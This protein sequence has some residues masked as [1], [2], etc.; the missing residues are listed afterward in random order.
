[1]AALGNLTASI[2]GVPQLV[3]HRESPELAAARGTV[4]FYHGF[5]GTKERADAYTSMLAE[6]G[7]GL[8]GVDAAAGAQPAP[9]PG[10]PSPAAVLSETAELDEFVP[11]EPIRDF[12]AK[13]QPWYAGEPD[14]VQDIGHSGVGHFLTPDLNGESCRRVVAWFGRWIPPQPGLEYPPISLRRV[15]ATPRP[16]SCPRDPPRSR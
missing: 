3:L 2:A 11:A 15:R 4:F 8:A 9:P 13:L 10:L 1:M 5:G 6:P 7:R 12:H 16:Q 14:R